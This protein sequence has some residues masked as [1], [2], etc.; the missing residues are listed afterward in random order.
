MCLFLDKIIKKLLKSYKGMGITVSI[1]TLHK[2]WRGIDVR[3]H[4][5]VTTA[6][7]GG[8]W[9]DSHSSWLSSLKMSLPNTHCTGDWV[10]TRDCLDGVKT[11]SPIQLLGIQKPISIHSPS[12]YWANTAP[13][14]IFTLLI[15][16][17]KV[18]SWYVERQTKYLVL[19]L[20]LLGFPYFQLM[21]TSFKHSY[22]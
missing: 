17:T 6:I 14:I 20:A 3:C 1:S 15:T 12:F 10:G 22:T 8:G 21:R 7:D 5:F 19:S 13:D 16:N 2:A 4:A 11:K 9:L 18:V